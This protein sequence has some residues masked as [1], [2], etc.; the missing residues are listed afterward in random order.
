M[1]NIAASQ[2]SFYRRNLKMI[3]VDFPSDY[4][5]VGKDMIDRYYI[6]FNTENNDI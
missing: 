5:L 1:Y 6:V 2:T 3:K 4:S